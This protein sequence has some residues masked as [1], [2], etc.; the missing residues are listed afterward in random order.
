M[1][2]VGLREIKLDQVQPVQ[3]RSGKVG[4]A[5]ARGAL[6]ARDLGGG[7][8]LPGQVRARA[9]ST[10]GPCRSGRGCR[11]AGYQRDQHGHRDGACCQRGGPRAWNPAV[12]AIGR[13]PHLWLL[14]DGLTGPAYQNSHTE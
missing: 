9:R 5:Q 3:V 4:A 8:P 10:S 12:S 7:D 11:R 2:Q 13:S 14:K 1:A 6:V